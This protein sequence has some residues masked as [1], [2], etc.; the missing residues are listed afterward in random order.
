MSDESGRR[1]NSGKPRK[2]NYKFP[3]DPRVIPHF[4]ITHSGDKKMKSASVPFS[5]TCF[6]IKSNFQHQLGRSP[7]QYHFL[8]RVS[9]RNL[10][11][12]IN[13]VV[14]VPFSPPCFKMK[15]NFHLK[16]VFCL[17]MPGPVFTILYYF[18]LLGSSFWVLGT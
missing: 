7:S 16:I 17:F 15:S 3:S 8:P 2:N 1:G 5:S 6:K 10:I 12:S 9:K 4:Y 11:S 14:S 13:S 18:T